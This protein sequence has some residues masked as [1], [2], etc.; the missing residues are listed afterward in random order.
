MMDKDLLQNCLSV[1]FSRNKEDLE[2]LGK[3]GFG[4]LIG[5]LSQCYRMEVYS[6]QGG[7]DIFHT[8]ID[9]PELIE[10]GNQNIPEIRLYQYL[11]R[12]YSW[13]GRN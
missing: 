10:N 8:Y 13:R 6:R 12:T 2:G 1:G 3:F 11:R 4:M 5:A 7:R 9:I